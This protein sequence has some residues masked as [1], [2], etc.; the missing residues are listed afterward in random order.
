MMTALFNQD[1]VRVLT[2]MSL[3]PGSRFFRKGLQ[4]KTRMNNACLDAALAILG[5]AG[6]LEKDG[7]SIIFNL[8]RARPIIAIVSAEYRLLKELPLDA[9]FSIS[10][11][12]RALARKKGVSLYL[13]GSYAKLVYNDRSDIDIAV[14]SDRVTAKDK[15]LLEKTVKKAK[16]QYGKAIEFHYFGTDIYKNRKDPLVKEVLGNSVKIL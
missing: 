6:I 1:I 7:R 4:E 15:R 9:Y 2:V 10:M 8:E 12:A 3:S 5:N 11:A 13:F 14:V 16:K